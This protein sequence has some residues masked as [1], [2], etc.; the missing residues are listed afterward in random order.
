MASKETSETKGYVASVKIVDVEKRKN[1]G[2]K[3]YVC[4]FL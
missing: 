4:L 3:Y 1:D 2:P